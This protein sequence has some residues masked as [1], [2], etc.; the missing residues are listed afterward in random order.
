MT[1]YSM[2]S[3]S[4]LSLTAQQEEWEA[5]ELKTQLDFSEVHIDPAP[6]QLVERTSL[7]K[8]STP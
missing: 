4:V 5:E 7:H 1:S 8:V 2:P 6:F 3:G